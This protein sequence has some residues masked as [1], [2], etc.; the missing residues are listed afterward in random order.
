M[1]IQD[2][3][4]MRPSPEP[5]RRSFSEDEV[6]EVASGF[7]QRHPMVLKVIGIFLAG[8]IIFGIIVALVTG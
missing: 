5:R 6:E 3:D 2:R 7:F 8:L 1:G 4:Y